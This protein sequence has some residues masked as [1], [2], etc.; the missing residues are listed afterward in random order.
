MKIAITLITDQRGYGLARYALASILASQTDAYDLYLHCDGFEP[1]PATDS[2]FDLARRVG[3][4]LIMRGVSDATYEGYGTAGHISTTTLKKFSAVRDLAGDYERVLYAD[5]DIL[6][7]DALPLSTEDFAGRPVAA[8][9]D[10]AESTGLTDPA[11]TENCRR[12]GVSPRY[13]NAGLMYF[14]TTACDMAALEARY[15]VLAADHQ[16]SCPYKAGCTTNDQCSFNRLFEDAWHALPVTWNVQA[17]ARFTPAWAKAAARHYTGPKKFLP[18]RPWRNDA[19][20]RRYLARLA[21]D[22]EQP[23]P[24]W[25]G[26]PSVIFPLN[27][28]LRGNEARTARAAVQT[29]ATWTA[30]GVEGCLG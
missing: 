4:R 12:G 29:V 7:F 14:D 1:P 3:R 13:F 18:I 22:L 30:T 21:A 25:S 28:K 10:I 5:T 19:R 6:H 8:V 26:W 24:A 11:F 17:C 20:D 23:A 9:Y 27:A 15:R 2:L 16:T